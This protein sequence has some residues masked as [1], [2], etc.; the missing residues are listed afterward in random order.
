MH[1]RLKTIFQILGGIF[2]LYLSIYYWNSVSSVLVNLIDAIIPVVGGF[3]IAYVLNILMTFYE[4]HYFPKWIDKPIV[5]KTRT[6][7]CLSAAIVSFFAIIYIIIRMIVPELIHCI[8]TLVKEIPPLVQKLIENDT[9]TKYVPKDVLK[10]LTEINWEDMISKIVN[11]V[12]DGIGTAAGAIIGVISSVISMVITVFV[13]IIFSI[14]FLLSKNK[15][16]MQSR[17]LLHCYAPKY[18]R[19]IL[20]FFSVFNDS[21]KKFIVGQCLEAVI[22]GVLCMLGMMIFKFPYPQMI[23]AFIGFTALIPVAGA[24]I[25]AAVGAIIILTVSPMKALLFL[26]FIIVLQ[27]IEGNLI[28]PRVVG[29]SI[30]LPAIWVLAAI[31]IGGGLMGIVGML[32]G[33]PICAALY[34]LIRENVLKREFEESIQCAPAKNNSSNE[35]NKK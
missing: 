20:H 34:R 27:Q 8:E 1:F 18:E 10:T 17:R 26:V 24:Y 32:I 5:K 9:V 3:S 19:K 4:R 25:G 11:F 22:L 30:G 6:I 7:V 15:L 33:V 2:L 29:N 28:Y 12:V 31:T 23:G 13:S 14:Y 21:F 35:G 16:Q